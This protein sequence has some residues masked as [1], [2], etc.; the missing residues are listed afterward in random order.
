[1]LSHASRPIRVL[2]DVEL[3]CAI[4]WLCEQAWC[5]NNFA[6]FVINHREPLGPQLKEVA[7]IGA[8]EIDVLFVTANP[9]QSIDQWFD[10]I[11]PC[12]FVPGC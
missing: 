5:E 7:G 3:T 8:G 11:R 12:T 4:R 9:D 10:M 1:M 2:V 6:D